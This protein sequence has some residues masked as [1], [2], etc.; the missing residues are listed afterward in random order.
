MG[1]RGQAARYAGKNAGGE[2]LWHY[3]GIDGCTN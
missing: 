2:L 1:R 3:I